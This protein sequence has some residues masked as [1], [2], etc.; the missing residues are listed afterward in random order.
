[1]HA[2]TEKA[3]GKYSSNVT[4]VPVGSKRRI[5]QPR[6]LRRSKYSPRFEIESSEA[7]PALEIGSDESYE[8]GTPNAAFAVDTESITEAVGR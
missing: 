8:P 3:V 4:E 6:H 1:M 2:V 7:V 5:L